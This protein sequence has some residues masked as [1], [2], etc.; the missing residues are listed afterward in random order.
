MYDVYNNAMRL[1]GELNVNFDRYLRLGNNQSVILG[2]SLRNAKPKYEIR[3]K[4]DDVTLRI[5]I[6]VNFFTHFYFQ[7]R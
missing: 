4:M 2:D 6:V 7:N 5:G 1:G 3:N